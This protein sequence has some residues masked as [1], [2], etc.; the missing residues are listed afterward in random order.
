MPAAIDRAPTVTVTPEQ[1][2]FFREN[3]YLTVESITTP[4]EVRAL[5]A[6]Y[7]R[8]F[9]QRA[10]REEGG[11]FDL[12]GSD[13]EGKPAVLPQILNP[14]KHAP[15]L[16]EIQ[17]RVNARAIAKQLLGPECDGGGSHAILKPA[18]Y[19]APTPWHQDEAYW[20]PSKEYC[21]LSVWI[22]FQDA[23]VENGCLWFVP[24][25]H[26]LAIL[27]HHRINND[28]RVHGLELD[29]FEKHTAG[30]VPCP[31]PAGGATFHRNS[32]LHYAGPNRSDGAR[33]ALIFGFGLPAKPR[34]EPRRFPWQ[35]V[36]ETPRQKRRAEWQ[37]K[38]K[39]IPGKK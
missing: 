25:S 23:T 6:V 17:A 8:I 3:G 28:P 32:T 22:P 21:S 39:S 29:D 34:T 27:P 5:Q 1:I 14:L 15:E 9:A 19:G 16:G 2:A 26:R 24:G 13:E 4:E 36:N 37:A 31:I 38:E 10:G 33:R 18:G 20:D 11:Q 7:D 35:E 12:G 30:A